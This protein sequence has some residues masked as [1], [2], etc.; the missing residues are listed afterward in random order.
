M[1]EM[2]DSLE[3]A[4]SHASSEFM[5]LGLSNVSHQD[6]QFSNHFGIFCYFLVDLKFVKDVKKNNDK[7]TSI[8]RKRKRSCTEFIMLM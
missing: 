3:V 2:N 6:F 1:K 8:W 5:I 4:Q 7:M